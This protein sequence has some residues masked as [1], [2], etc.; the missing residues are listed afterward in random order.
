[1][2]Q[3]L[4]GAGSL[5]VLNVAVLVFRILSGLFAEAFDVLTQARQKFLVAVDP[6]IEGFSEHLVA[7]F[8]G[9]RQQ[10]ADFGDECDEPEQALCDRLSTANLLAPA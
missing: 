1:M 5:L 9:F 3:R 4:L 6:Q 7:A 2:H 8:A 10:A